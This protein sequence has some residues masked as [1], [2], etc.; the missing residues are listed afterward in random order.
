MPVSG[1]P[2]DPEGVAIRPG[3]DEM[4]IAFDQGARIASFTYTPTLPE[5]ADPRLYKHVSPRMDTMGR[6]EEIAALAAY[7]ASDEARFV[8]G[9]AMTIDGGQGA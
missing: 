1:K 4:F 7:L 2:S 9:S 3:S 5:G 8:T 6:P